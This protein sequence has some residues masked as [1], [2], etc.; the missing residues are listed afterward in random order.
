MQHHAHN[1]C[2]IGSVGR[3]YYRPRRGGDGI[4]H[5]GRSLMSTIGLL[6]MLSFCRGGWYWCQSWLISLSMSHW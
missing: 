4:A 5:C 1:I 3:V 6:F 2:L